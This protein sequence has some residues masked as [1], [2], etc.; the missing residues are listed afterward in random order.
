M[1]RT[2]CCATLA[3]VLAATGTLALATPPQ[4]DGQ[5][6]TDA[7]GNYVPN[8]QKPDWQRRVEQQERDQRWQ[9]R[10]QEWQRQQQEQQRRQAENQRRND[11][12]WQRQQEWELQRRAD[13]QR[14]HDEAWQR[15]Q[16][17]IINR[18]A[19]YPVYDTGRHHHWERG[20]RYDG[21]V[22]VVRDYRSYRLREPP[23]G[24]H[25]VRADNDYLLVAVA[26]GVILDIVNH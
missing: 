15:Q 16:E 5:W 7:R 14:R 6:H 26:T 24:Y 3:V 17:S 22:Y 23:R 12:A 20:R 4:D 10:N 9:E 19:G 8:Y 21:P 13:D 2:V 18:Q 11:E 1:F 25:W